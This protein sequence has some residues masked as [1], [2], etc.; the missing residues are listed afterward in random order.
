MCAYNEEFDDDYEDEDDVQETP[1]WLSF[2]S[3]K[4]FPDGECYWPE[5]LEG[6]EEEDF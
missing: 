1:S 4:M 6:Y 3:Y 5:E 2:G